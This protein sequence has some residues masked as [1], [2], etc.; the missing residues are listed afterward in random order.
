MGACIVTDNHVGARLG[1]R[2]GNGSHPPFLLASMALYQSASQWSLTSLI[3]PLPGGISWI[4][5][6]A[7][8]EPD[9]VLNTTSLASISFTGPAPIFP[10]GRRPPLFTLMDYKNHRAAEDTTPA[11]PQEP[12][13]VT[14]PTIPRMKVVLE[15]KV[16]IDKWMVRSCCQPQENRL[17]SLT[18]KVQRATSPST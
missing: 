2:L 16:L 5:L 18:S 1:L 11:E 8:S 7:L 10:S 6:L 9:T 15:E 14:T 3:L 4:S 12:V 13:M 17:T